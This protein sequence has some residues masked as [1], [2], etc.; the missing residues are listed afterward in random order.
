MAQ[1]TSFEHVN[2]SVAQCLEI[3][4]DRWSLLIIR[5]AFYGVR[6]FDEFQAR[7]GIARNILNRRLVALIDAGILHRVPYQEH[8]PRFEYRLTER[9]RDLWPIIAALRQWGDTWAAPGGP[10]LETRHVA[11]GQ[12]ADTVTVCSRCGDVLGPSDLRVEPGPGAHGTELDRTPLANGRSGSSE[13]NGLRR[14]S[15]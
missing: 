7:L 3:V 6:R 2:C 13:P 14:T 5:D 4:G 12:I 8:P 1:R 11:C 10:P 9:G 15:R